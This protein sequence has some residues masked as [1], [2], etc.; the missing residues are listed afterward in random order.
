MRPA[1]SFF[2]PFPNDCWPACGFRHGS[3]Q[4]GDEFVILLS[5]I[6]HPED[7]AKAQKRYFFR[8]AH[9]TP[10]RDK[11]CISG[12]IGISVYPEDGKDAEALI[13]N[14][15]TAMY[16]AKGTGRNNFQF[17]KVI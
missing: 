5:E 3:R 13:K 4:G 12:S 17:F 15:D 10:S 7:A 16:H 1:T 14:A 8:S 6:S 9:R 2:V 11:T